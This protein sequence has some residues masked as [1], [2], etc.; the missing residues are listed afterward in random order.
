[1][2]DMKPTLILVEPEGAGERWKPIVCDTG[3]YN[4]R[5]LAE[6]IGLSLSGLRKRL[7]FVGWDH[8]EILAGYRH[9]FSGPKRSDWNTKRRYVGRG[10]SASDEFQPE[11]VAGE[12]A[13]LGHR[14]RNARLATIPRPTAWDLS[15]G[16]Q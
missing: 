12:F 13:H 8:Q 16:A 5:D 9:R 7:R 14:P 1:M 4:I 3:T 10:P 11:I 2:S 15:L 6:M